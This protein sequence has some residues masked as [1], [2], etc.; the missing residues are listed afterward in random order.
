MR[1]SNN[2][3]Q[4]I[5]NIN[6]AVLILKLVKIYEIGKNVYLNFSYFT[7]FLKNRNIISKIER[8][9]VIDYAALIA[10]TQL[11]IQNSHCSARFIISDTVLKFSA[12]IHYY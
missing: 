9:K 7:V 10:E 5:F 2:Y 8:S 3:R 12:I 6:A 4:L 1:P 11:Y